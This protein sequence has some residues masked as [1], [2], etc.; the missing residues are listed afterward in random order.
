MRHAFEFGMQLDHAIVAQG[1]G[2]FIAVVEELK[3]RLQLVVTVFTATEDVQHQIEF[4]R[5]GQCQCLYSHVIAPV[6]AVASP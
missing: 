6:C 5:G 4:C 3:Q 1:E 2:Q